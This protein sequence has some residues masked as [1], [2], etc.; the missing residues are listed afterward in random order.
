M[1]NRMRFIVAAAGVSLGLALSSI[2]LAERPNFTVQDLQP[3][4][5]KQ[6]E[7]WLRNCCRVSLPVAQF[8][9]RGATTHSVLKQISRIVTLSMAHYVQSRA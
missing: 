7:K 3:A 8:G 6:P 1:L 9:S 2:A 5:I 4:Q